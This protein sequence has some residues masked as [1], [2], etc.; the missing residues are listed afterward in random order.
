M[1]AV[2]GEDGSPSAIEI[3][4]LL[5]R[6]LLLLALE[7][8]RHDDQHDNCDCYDNDYCRQNHPHH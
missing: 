2:Q 6:T 3:E 8:G 7:V 1:V 4:R 5:M